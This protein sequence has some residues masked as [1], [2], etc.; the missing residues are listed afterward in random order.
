MA[1]EK[2]KDQTIAAGFWVAL[3]LRE[4]TAPLRSYVGEVQTVDGNGIRLTLIDWI[5]LTLNGFDLFV[6]WS[7]IEAA[8]IAT[9]EHN[10]ERFVEEAKAWPKSVSSK[11]SGK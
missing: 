3:T 10:S 7:N 9:P 6:P 1:M 5:S 8:L 11:T 2:Y 4:G